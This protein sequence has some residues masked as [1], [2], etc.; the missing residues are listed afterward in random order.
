FCVKTVPAAAVNAPD[1]MMPSSAMLMTPPRSEYIPPSAAR[2]NGV[3][4]RIID[5]SNERLMMFLIGSMESRVWSLESRVRVS[6][7]P[8]A[9]F[10]LQTLDFSAHQPLCAA[11]KDGFAGDK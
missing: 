11:A 3:D 4:S 1:S 10:R 5:A 7:S 2:I 6:V 8:H 9:L